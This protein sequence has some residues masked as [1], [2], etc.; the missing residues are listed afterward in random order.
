MRFC[1]MS[2]RSYWRRCLVLLACVA[3]VRSA[4]AGDECKICKDVLQ[5]PALP[6]PIFIFVHGAFSISQRAQFASDELARSN[7]TIDDALQ[8]ILKFTIATGLCGPK[9]AIGAVDVCEGALSEYGQLVVDIIDQ[10]P[11]LSLAETDLCGLLRLCPLALEPRVPPAQILAPIK[12]LPSASLHPKSQYAPSR[13]NIGHFTVITDIHWDPYYA[14]G[15]ITN[16]DHPMCCRSNYGPRADVLAGKT[17]AQLAGEWGD[18]ACDPPLNIV[19]ATLSFASTLSADFVLFTGDVPPHDVWNQSSTYNMATLDSVMD[20]LK[21]HFP[22]VPVFPSVGNHDTFPCDQFSL[23]QPDIY[24]SIA[25]SWARFLPQPTLQTVAM[26]AF[27]RSPP[28]L[29]P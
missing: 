21:H 3:A 6:P 12:P 19:N 29:L 8:H 7:S 2:F 26:G 22:T 11:F 14:V 17:Q 18:Y 4:Y 27:Y 15:S 13:A 25:A 24:S 5:V 16:C 9:G 20:L 10:S 1:G 23:N 28:P